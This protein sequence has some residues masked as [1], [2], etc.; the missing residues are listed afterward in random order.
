MEDLVDRET[1]GTH[2]GHFKFTALQTALTIF[3]SCAVSI[4]V[5][6][7]VPSTSASSAGC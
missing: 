2:L 7:Q 1:D 4:L 3:I 6:D 5:I